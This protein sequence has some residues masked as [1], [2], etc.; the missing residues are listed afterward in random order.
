MKTT[1][2]IIL[3]AAGILCAGMGH[4][5]SAQRRDREVFQIAEVTVNRFNT[6]HVINTNVRVSQVRVCAFNDDLRLQRLAVTLGNGRTFTL[7]QNEYVRARDCTQWKDLRGDERRVVQV[8]LVGQSDRDNRSTR[9]LIQGRADNDINPRQTWQPWHTTS[10][11]D[12]N[13]PYMKDGRNNLI[14]TMPCPNRNPNGGP[15]G[16]SC[17]NVAR[18]TLCYGYAYQAEPGFY[19]AAPNGRTPPNPAYIYSMYICQ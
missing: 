2:K 10:C 18:E 8:L 17:G 15:T 14:Y 3:L 6:R 12:A 5:A 13:I 9:V 16:M 19:C 1:A 7:A 4:N 11:G